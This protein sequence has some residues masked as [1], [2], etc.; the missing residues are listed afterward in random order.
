[1]TSVEPASSGPAKIEV[2]GF[3][4]NMRIPLAVSSGTLQY[5]N[6]GFKTPVTVRE[7]EKVVVGTTSMQDKGLVI[8][9]TASVIK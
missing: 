6:I 5:E 2:G 9:I 8:V 4:F 7:G 1:M 3:A